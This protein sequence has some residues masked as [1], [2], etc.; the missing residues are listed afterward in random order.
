MAFESVDNRLVTQFNAMIHNVAQQ[1]QA[2]FRPWAEEMEFK[3]DN[4]AYDS[5]GDIEARELTGRFNK[6]VFDDIEFQRRKITKRRFGVTLPVDKHD[7]EGMMTDPKGALAT[8]ALRAME[9]Q[10]DRVFYDC[11]GADIQTGREF[12]TTVTAAA[13]GVI[14][15]NATAGVTLAKLLEV[16]QN[17][18][19]NEV[20]NDLPIDIGL[21][22][23]GDEHTALLGILQLTSQDYSRDFV[24]EKGT[25]GRAAGISLI[26][27]GASARNP[28]LQVSGGVRT[29]YAFAKGAVAMAIARNWEVNVEKRNDI[30]DTWQVQVVGVLGGVRIEG[31]LVQKFTSTD[32]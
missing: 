15:V 14:T 2:R 31:K 29:S 6:V 22:I 7:L 26:P 13:D 28:I 9:R 11:L 12:S 16:R 3:G 10:Y 23:S 18:I 5:L 25:I 27:F 21:A 1:T 19:D 30:Y 8:A 20:G 4:M 24:L 32:S 17:F